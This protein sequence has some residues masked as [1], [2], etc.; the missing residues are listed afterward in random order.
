MAENLEKLERINISNDS[1]ISIVRQLSVVPRY[2]SPHSVV[3]KL[4]IYFKTMQ[5]ILIPL[6]IIHQHDTNYA[7][8]NSNTVSFHLDRRLIDEIISRIVFDTLTFITCYTRG[9]GEKNVWD[10]RRDESG[11]KSR[12]LPGPG[13]KTG[14]RSRSHVRPRKRGHFARKTKPPGKAS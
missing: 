3:S 5:K 4:V 1:S 13:N 10:W 14:K 2:L 8:L 6:F 7:T 9:G 11:R 12:N